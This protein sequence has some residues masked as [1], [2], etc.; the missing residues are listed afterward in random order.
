MSWRPEQYLEKLYYSTIPKY[1]FCAQD[2]VQWKQWRDNLKET[3]INA[4][5]GF[6]KKKV[7]L[8]SRLLEEEE[9]RDHIRQRVVFT[10]MENLEVPSYVLIPKNRTG[11]LPAV[12]ACHGHGYGSK[13]IVGML[14]SLAY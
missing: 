10:S 2:E 7:E 14:P 5:G 11:K 8:N 4:L 12:I 9:L 13:D 3:F 1:S 6:P